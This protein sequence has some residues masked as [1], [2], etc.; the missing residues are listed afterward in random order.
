MLRIATTLAVS[1]ASTQIARMTVTAS[2]RPVVM[3]ASVQ[4]VTPRMIVPSTST[5]AWTTNVRTARLASTASPI[6]PAFAIAAGRDG[7]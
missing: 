4:P 2:T 3:S 7:C 6:T 1:F 5:N